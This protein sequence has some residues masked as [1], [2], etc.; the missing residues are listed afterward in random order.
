[1]PCTCV[2]MLHALA[3]AMP[4]WFTALVL[5]L[6]QKGCIASVKANLLLVPPLT[7]GLDRCCSGNNSTKSTSKSGIGSG[8]IAGIVVGVAIALALGA[9]AT[10]VYLK[11][12]RSNS[13]TLL[14]VQSSGGFSRFEDF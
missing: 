7:E 12:K 6:L 5:L 3:D 11:R 2:L 10:A 13:R 9:A 1:M 8:A 4:N 14:R